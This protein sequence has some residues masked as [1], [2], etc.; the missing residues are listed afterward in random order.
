[1]GTLLDRVVESYRASYLR[2]T[3][4]VTSAAKQIIAA[5]GLRNNAPTC[6]YYPHTRVCT[7]VAFRWCGHLYA[8]HQGSTIVVKKTMR[9]CPIGSLCT[10]SPL[11]TRRY[12]H[13]TRTTVLVNSA[14][15]T[16]SFHM[17]FHLKI[18]EYTKKLHN[19]LNRYYALCS[20]RIL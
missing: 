19:F 5:T 7:S 8:K 9:W 6:F 4:T 10:L 15:I 18:R 1:M 11:Q 16:L 14:A 2:A 3:S 17:K 13:P 20:S 12:M